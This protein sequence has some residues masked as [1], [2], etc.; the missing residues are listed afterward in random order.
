MISLEG[1]KI[2]QLTLTFS[3]WQTAYPPARHLLTSH[4]NDPNPHAACL[5][6]EQ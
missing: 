5:T 4:I 6:P 1:V 3:S 2:L